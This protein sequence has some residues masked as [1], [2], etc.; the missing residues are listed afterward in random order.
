[1][2][3][4]KYNLDI[5]NNL[6][7]KNDKKNDD[8]NIIPFWLND[9]NVLFQQQYIFEFYPT[10]YMT[11]EQKLNTITSRTPNKKGSLQ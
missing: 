7:E 10:E 8:E 3:P 11:Y 5:S 6:L 4:E 9:P 1:M 2:Q